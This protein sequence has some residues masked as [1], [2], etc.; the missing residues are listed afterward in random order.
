ME[1]VRRFSEVAF[2]RMTSVAAVAA[3]PEVGSLGACAQPYPPQLDQRM[4]D[5]CGVH[6][7]QMVE[8]FFFLVAR[9]LEFSPGPLL[10][11]PL[12]AGVIQCGSAGLQVDHR[13]VHSGITACFHHLVASGQTSPE[14]AGAVV[15]ALS[16]HGTSLVGAIVGCLASDRMTYG[17]DKSRSNPASVLWQISR[18]QPGGPTVLSQLL[19]AALAS[20]PTE[21]SSLL[22]AS[23]HSHPPLSPGWCCPGVFGGRPR[24]V[25]AGA[26]AVHRRDGRRG[27]LQRRAGVRRQLSPKRPPVHAPRKVHAIMAS[28]WPRECGARWRWARRFCDWRPA[29]CDL[30][31]LRYRGHA[32]GCG[33]GPGNRSA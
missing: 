6:A 21:A 13:G 22:F 24:G 12:L 18:L 28:A 33:S 3:C 25:A 17:L 4:R 16:A 11:S 20:V 2:A 32:R 31:A 30:R 1:M 10:A 19:V 23:R 5:L 14:H 8:E 15:A 29:A 27:L 7:A 9:F 26:R